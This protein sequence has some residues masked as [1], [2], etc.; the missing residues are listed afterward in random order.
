[1]TMW[2]QLN[3]LMSELLSVYQE[4]LALSRQKKDLL[5]RAKP[6]DLEKVVKQ[7]EVLVMKAGRIEVA[8]KQ[9]ISNLVSTLVSKQAVPEAFTLEELIA[10]APAEVAEQLKETG[11]DFALVLQDLQV[12][13][14]LN[15]KLIQQALN[16][17]N[18]N[19]NL[20]ANSSVGPTYSAP[21]YGKQPQEQLSGHYNRTIFDHKV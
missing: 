16:L 7:E 5:V 9:V 20:L 2:E 13:N 4:I 19:I 14:E 11:Q 21:G 3:D 1:M 10:L 12:Q 17:V 15:T 18:Y 8:R 6:A